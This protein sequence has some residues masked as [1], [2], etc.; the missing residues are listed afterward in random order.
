M[1]GTTRMVTFL[2]IAN[3]W[4]TCTLI[5]ILYLPLAI[6]LSAGGGGKVCWLPGAKKNQIGYVASYLFTMYYYVATWQIS[7]VLYVH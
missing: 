6:Y 7:L 2:A 1:S 5:K 3:I 4:I